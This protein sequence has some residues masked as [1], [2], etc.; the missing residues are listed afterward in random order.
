M[1]VIGEV[2]DVPERIVA[3]YLSVFSPRVS[4]LRSIRFAVHRIRFGTFTHDVT[5]SVRAAVLHYERTEEIRGP[6]TSAFYRAIMGDDDAVVLD[7]HMADAMGIDQSS[8]DT[9]LKYQRWATIFAECTPV[10]YTP[11]QF[12]AAVW[13]GQLLSR[14]RKVRYISE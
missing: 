9:H 7:V 13:A 3:G 1:A 8:F 6:K 2:F 11:A 5:R 12:Q 4:V 10:G 14:N